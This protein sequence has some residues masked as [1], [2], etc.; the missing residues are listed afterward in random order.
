MP[1][2]LEL[3]LKIRINIETFLDHLLGNWQCSKE[4][5]KAITFE[6]VNEKILC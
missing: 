5:R 3:A 2:R 6:K 1:N 4:K